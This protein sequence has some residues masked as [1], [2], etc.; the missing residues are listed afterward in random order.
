M[1]RK[2]KK[3]IKRKV[4]KRSAWEA[5]GHKLYTKYIRI[6]DDRIA[7]VHHHR[8]KKPHVAFCILRL[9]KDEQC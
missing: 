7:Y 4:I 6:Y 1:T 8:P 5:N 3:N 9:N 2:Q